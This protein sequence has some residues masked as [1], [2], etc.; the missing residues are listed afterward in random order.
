MSRDHAIRHV[1]ADGP[2]QLESIQLTMGGDREEVRATLKSMLGR[3][4]IYWT[5]G[6]YHL[7]RPERRKHTPRVAVPRTQSSFPLQAFW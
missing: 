6:W 5:Q 4:E 7:N 1:L 3:H 2:M